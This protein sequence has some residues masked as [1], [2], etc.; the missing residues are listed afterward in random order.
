MSS[1]NPSGLRHT[2]VSGSAA[3]KGNMIVD[4]GGGTTW[5]YGEFSIDGA[6]A[7]PSAGMDRVQGDYMGMLATWIKPKTTR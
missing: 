6:R 7:M 1:L 3:P 5:L 4:I 2:I